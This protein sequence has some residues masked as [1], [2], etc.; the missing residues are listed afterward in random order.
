MCIQPVQFCMCIQAVQ[1][2]MCIQAV[3][4]RVYADTHKFNVR[5]NI[6]TDTVYTAE[7]P[8]IYGRM[9]PTTKLCSHTRTLTG[10]QD[11]LHF[12]I[13][14][15]QSEDVC[16]QPVYRS[17]IGRKQ[18]VTNWRQTTFILACV[19]LVNLTFHKLQIDSG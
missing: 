5:P 11:L 6:S 17:F 8:F 3:Q 18:K 14:C 7:N 4:F 19:K 15:R 2:C 16:V 9:Y 13:Q 10:H 1:C 12:K